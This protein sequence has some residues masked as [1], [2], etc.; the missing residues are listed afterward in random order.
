[1]GRMVMSD[2][3][4]EAIEK[5][6]FS[7]PRICEWIEL[8]RAAMHRF[9]RREA[10][11]S[12]HVLDR[13]ADLLWLDVTINPS[14]KRRPKM[15]TSVKDPRNY[16]LRF[17]NNDFYDLI[18]IPPTGITKAGEAETRGNELPAGSTLCHYRISILKEPASGDVRRHVQSRTPDSVYD[19]FGIARRVER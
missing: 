3:I 9:M 10:G 5:S 8:D 12:M 15:T 13:L 6:G 4:R 16:R 7:Q 18:K 14:K 17:V 11:L 19:K 1:M 2:Q